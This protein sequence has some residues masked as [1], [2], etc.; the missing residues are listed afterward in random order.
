MGV[1]RSTGRFTVNTLK[2]AAGGVAI[3][4]GFVVMRRQWRRLVHKSCPKC[5]EGM[6]CSFYGEPV[7]SVKPRFRGCD[8]CDHYEAWNAESD[9]DSM[10]RLRKIADERLFGDEKKRLATLR[11]MRIASRW[12]YVFC[13]LCIGYAVYV[14]LVDQA[15]LRFLNMMGVTFFMFVKGFAA[16]YR[17]WQVKENIVFVPGSFWRWVKLGKWLV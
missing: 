12:W 1:L 5:A 9:K 15:L 3:K 7:D 13:L 10:K 8:S 16:A 14:L 2:Y 4:G 11:N 17:H 6:L